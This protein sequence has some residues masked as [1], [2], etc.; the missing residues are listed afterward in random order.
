MSFATSSLSRV[1]AVTALLGSVALAAPAFAAAP[2]TP[3]APATTTATPVKHHGHKSMED[4]VET[5]IKTLHNKLGITPDQETAWNDVAQT[6]RDNEAS[7]KPLIEE[8]H[9]NAQTMTAVQD[10]MSYQKIAQAHADGLSKVASAFEPL[11]DAMND[12][13]KKN[14]DEVFGR[15]EGHR[16]GHMAMTKT[17]GK[18]SAS[19]TPNE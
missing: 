4:R 15:F 1:L 17:P 19:G 2:T 12:Q 6:M 10:L 5:R 16:E 3:T 13:Q 8:R 11:Y 7:I 9:Q 18:K 14:A